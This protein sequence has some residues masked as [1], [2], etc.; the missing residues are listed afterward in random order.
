[1]LFEQVSALRVESLEFFNKL[2]VVVAVDWWHFAVV[3]ERK[4]ALWH[5]A[6]DVHDELEAGFLEVLFSFLL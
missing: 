5:F 6:K 2:T 4:F 1:M 3:I